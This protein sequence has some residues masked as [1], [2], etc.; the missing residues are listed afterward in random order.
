M[1]IERYLG[2]G[3]AYFEKL[4]ADGT[5]ETKREIGEIQG[6]TLSVKLETE[7]AYSQDDGFAE[8]VMELEKKK[9]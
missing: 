4:K 9:I 2:G 3:R 5:Y 6:L 7:Q 8:L 1:A